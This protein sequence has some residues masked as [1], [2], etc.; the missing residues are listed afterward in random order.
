ML[1][2]A[3]QFDL[4]DEI[5]AHNF[6]RAA[7]LLPSIGMLNLE[8]IFELLTKKTK[9]IVNSVSDRRKVQGSERI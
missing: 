7:L 5:R 2:A 6:P 9:F 8:A 1:N 4:L 3:I